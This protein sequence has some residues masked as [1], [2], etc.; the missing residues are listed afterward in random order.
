VRV[1]LDRTYRIQLVGSHPICAELRQRLVYE[2]NFD[3]FPGVITTSSELPE[4]L[5]TTQAD[6]MLIDMALAG[7]DLYSILQDMLPHSDVAPYL[8]GI[9]RKYEPHLKA[10]YNYRPLVR[11]TLRRRM[12]LS[13]LLRPV[14]R[15]IATGCEYF[16]PPPLYDDRHRLTTHEFQVLTHMALGM[17]N[18]QLAETLKV[19][20]TSIYNAQSKMRRKLGVESNQKA[21]V[22]AIRLGLV[23]IFTGAEDPTNPGLHMNVGQTA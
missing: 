18:A 19:K 8:V 9:D 15:G 13:P 11:G 4:A 20:M 12:A 23:G 5:S 10:L 14:M 16:L 22:T 3:V 6:L 21:I 1:S 2:P 17:D 7:D